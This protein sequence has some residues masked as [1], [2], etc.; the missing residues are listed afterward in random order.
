MALEGQ[1][2]AATELSEDGLAVAAT[3]VHPIIPLAAS[4]GLLE[5]RDS[6]MHCAQPIIKIFKIIKEK[7]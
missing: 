1:V 5:T 7:G 2:S 6:R 3:A 4:E